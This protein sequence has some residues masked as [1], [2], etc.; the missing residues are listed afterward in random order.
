MESDATW[1]LDSP[2]GVEI[3]GSGFSATL[4]DYGRFGLFMLHGG[5][6]GSDSMLPDGWTREATTPK[7]LRGGTPLEYGYLWWPGTTAA[8]HRDGAYAALGIYGQALYVNPAARI[9][10][11][12]WAAQP[13]PTG[14]DVVND[15]LFF[16]AVVAA[17]GSGGEG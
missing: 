16:D 3:G 6:V 15:W 10:I 11:V 1:W 12:V 4:R 8:A 13:K 7:M 2:D 14:G 5:V 9:V 17:L